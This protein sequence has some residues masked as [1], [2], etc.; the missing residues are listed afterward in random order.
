M[1]Y[2]TVF[3]VGMLLNQETVLETTRLFMVPYLH[4][5]VVKYHQWMENPQLRESTSSDLLSLDEELDAQQK[6]CNSD[7]RLTFILLSKKLIQ[8]YW[9][10]GS[11]QNE[12]DT[13]SRLS[14]YETL[15]NAN[16]EVFAMIGDVNLFLLLVVTM[17]LKVNYL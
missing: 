8:E 13:S 9:L 17:V 6:W 1:Y 14:V 4:T 16:P 11:V 2:L 7:D 3:C 15:D 12:I 10:S 5:H